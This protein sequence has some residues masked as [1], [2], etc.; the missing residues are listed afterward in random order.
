MGVRFAPASER[1]ARLEWNVH[2]ARQ[3]RLRQLETGNPFETRSVAQE[4]RRI[5]ANAF[6]FLDVDTSEE[7]DV[8]RLSPFD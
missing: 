6:D 3:G 5:D 1:G 8:T 7:V 4:A 2:S